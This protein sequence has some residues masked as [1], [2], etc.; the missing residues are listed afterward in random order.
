MADWHAY[1]AEKEAFV[2]GQVGSSVVRINVVCSTALASY[3]LWASTRRYT[4]CARCPATTDWLLLVVPM[5]LACTAL[6]EHIGTLF[7]GMMSLAA[8]LHIASGAPSASAAPPN[9]H[10]KVAHAPSSRRPDDGAVTKAPRVAPSPVLTVYRT[11]LMVLTVLCILAVDFRVF[12]RAFAKCETWGTSLMDLGVG[13][14]VFSHGLVSVRT[15]RRPHWRRTARRT[16]PLWVLGLARVVLV[17]R[18]EY[19]EHVTEYGVHWNFF[20]TLGVVIPAIDV[21]QAYLPHSMGIMGVAL[22]AVY[23]V[24]L[25]TTPLAAWAL[26]DARD[27]ASIVS[28]NK[29]GL[30]SLPGTSRADPGYLAIAML[31]LDVGTFVR[32]TEQVIPRL[33][34]RACAYWVLYAAAAARGLVASRRMVCRRLTQANL[35]YVIWT[36]AF[37]TLFLLCF[38][39]LHTLWMRYEP[40]ATSAPTLFDWINRHSLQVFLLVRHALTQSNVATGLINLRIQTMHCTTPEAMHILGAYLAVVLGI[41]PWATTHWPSW[42]SHRK[43]QP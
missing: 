38:A 43:N 37:N 20:L 14:F 21:L 3:V 13:S 2:A 28:L 12:P 15:Q 36:A 10:H 25:T 29:E 16:L 8:V 6:S 18:T 42:I 39:A 5:S 32:K 1:K 22:S 34:W 41:V 9:P 40:R 17:K 31:G 7:L 27:A 19:P 11:Y 33:A 23:E 26:S 30:T 4:L 35:S 24:V